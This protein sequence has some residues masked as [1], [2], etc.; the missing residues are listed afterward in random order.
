MAALY[1]FSLKWSA[2]IV[3]LAHYLHSA[4]GCPISIKS[5]THQQAKWSVATLPVSGLTFI[6][7]FCKIFICFYNGLHVLLL[8]SLLVIT[9]LCNKLLLVIAHLC[10]TTTMIILL[11][12]REDTEKLCNHHTPI[13]KLKVIKVK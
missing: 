8:D 2:N 12:K 5:V 7:C 10:N 4:S 11:L 3:H 13:N 6:I 9:Y 1:I